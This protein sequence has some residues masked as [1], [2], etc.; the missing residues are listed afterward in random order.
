M[1]SL[2]SLLQPF[3]MHQVDAYNK[4]LAIKIYTGITVDLPP[5]NHLIGTHYNNKVQYRK[6]QCSVYRG[7]TM[8]YFL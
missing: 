2:A 6:Q 5:A 1:C 8:H 7:L 4:N 3:K